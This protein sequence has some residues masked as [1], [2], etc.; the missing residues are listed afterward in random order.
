MN[1]VLLDTH[2][3]LWWLSAPERLPPRALAAMRSPN[4]EVL[5]SSVSTAELAVKLG[6]G[7]LTLPVPLDR[8]V[9]DLFLRDGFTGLPFTHDHALALARL[10]LHHRDPFDRMLVAQAS[11]EAV[12]IVT[13]D[14]ALQQYAV[15][16]L[17]A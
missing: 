7:R 15:T 8:L 2:A 12:P 1:R 6:I 14:A 16:I 5:F 4:T 10:P 17:W 3:V 13:A 11:A 9:S